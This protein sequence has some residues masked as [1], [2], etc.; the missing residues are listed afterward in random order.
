MKKTEKS[1]I[2]AP[3]AIIMTSLMESFSNLLSKFHR[4]IQKIGKFDEAKVLTFPVVWKALQEE[5]KTV[6][7]M[8]LS[9]Q[10]NLKISTPHMS[11]NEQ[12]K[13]K[14][15]VRNKMKR[16]YSYSQDAP[17]PDNSYLK[18][19]KHEASATD[20]VM[21]HNALLTPSLEYLPLIA[22][23]VF[24]FSRSVTRDYDELAASDNILNAFLNDVFKQ[25]YMP[26][27]EDSFVKEMNFL[28]EID[29]FQLDLNAGKPL[30][31]VINL[32]K[33]SLLSS[34]LI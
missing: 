9:M 30:F 1:F 26:F 24:D 13:S 25:L 2:R 6:F 16:L 33:L 12:L 32:L 3:S 5:I 4:V 14:R 15:P 8:H 21:C 28:N 7:M 34:F 11:I 17:L 27:L 22:A 23:S 19:H 29:A 31:K 18:F 20:S 10:P